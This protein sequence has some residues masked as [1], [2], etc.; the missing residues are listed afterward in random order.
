MK[1]L[2]TRIAARISGFAKPR[3]QTKQLQ[4]GI[5]SPLF[6][7]E[8]RQE[9]VNPKHEEHISH[10]F[11]SFCKNVLKRTVRER[12]RQVK[13]RGEREVSFSDLSAR[14]LAKLIVA[15]EY[16]TDGCVFSV[17]GESVGVSDFDLAEAL[18][19]LP[20]SGRDIVLM[21]YFFDMTDREIAERLNM[22]RRTVTYR[23]AATLREL[24]KFMESED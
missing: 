1:G 6:R 21:S 19:E 24:K 16:F 12:Y 22:V 3:F 8:R 17:L 4:R 11:D 13:R 9:I 14:D 10:S 23:R 20:A 5:T 7:S 18:K 2:H 15:D